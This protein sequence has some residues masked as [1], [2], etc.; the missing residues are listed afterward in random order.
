[1]SKKSGER[2]SVAESEPSPFKGEGGPLAV[3]EVGFAKLTLCKS[4]IIHCVNCEIFASQFRVF[5]FYLFFPSFFSKS[6]RGV[7]WNPTCW[8]FFSLA[9]LCAAGVKEKRRAV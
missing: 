2:F 3:D 8:R 5:Y 6:S 4:D 9:F 7:G 1:M